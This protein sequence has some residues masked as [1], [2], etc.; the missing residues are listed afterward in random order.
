MVGVERR[1]LIGRPFSDFIVRDDRDVFYLHRRKLC[2]TMTSQTCELRIRQQD[3]SEFYAHLKSIMVPEEKTELQP[4]TNCRNRY[5]C[6]QTG[7]R[8]T[9]GI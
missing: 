3:G 7:R 4:D 5:T 1:S 8:C 6:A 2:E 9:A